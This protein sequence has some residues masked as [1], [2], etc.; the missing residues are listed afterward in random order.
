MIG[1]NWDD[2]QHLLRKLAWLKLRGLSAER[3]RTEYARR[4]D[5][6]AC[7]AQNH[8]EA[9]RLGRKAAHSWLDTLK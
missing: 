2:N 6:A 7:L 1:H 5:E 4:W 9:E 3:V 8:Y